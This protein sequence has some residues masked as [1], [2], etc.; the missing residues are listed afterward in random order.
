MIVCSWVMSDWGATHSTVPAATAGLDQ[1]MPDASFFG[2]ALAAAVAAGS[3]SQTRVD[4]MATRMLVPMYALGMIDNPPT[5]SLSANAS[6]LAHDTLARVLAEQSTVLLKN[7]GNILPLSSKPGKSYLILGDETTVTGHGSGGVVTPYIITPFQGI[8]TYLNGPLPPRPLNCTFQDNCD[9]Y[10]PGNPCVSASDPQDCCAQCT[11]SESCN[12]FTFVPNATCGTGPDG[13]AAAAT[14]ACWLK[15]DNSGYTPHTGY[16]SGSC[17][18][19]PAPTGGSNVTVYAGQNATVAAAMAASYDYVIISVATTSSEGSDRPDLTLPSWQDAMVTAVAAVN[20]NTI[21][22]ARCPGACFMVWKDQVPAILFSLMPGQEAG[23]AIA[24]VIFGDVN[25]SGKLPVS[26]PASMNDTWLGNPVNPLQYP[27]TQRNNSWLEADYSENLLIGYRWYDQQNINPLW[28][29]GHGLSYS[30]WTYSGL[31]VTGTV[32]SSSNATVS[33]TITN[34]GPY[35]AAE[36]AQLYLGFPTAADEPPKLLKKFQKVKDVAVNAANTINFQITI[37]DVQVW[38]T[39]ADAW[40]VR[41]LL[42]PSKGGPMSF[43]MCFLMC[44]YTL[45]P[46]VSLWAPP[47]V[48]C[49]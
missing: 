49:D 21:V 29:F 1:Q 18:P 20:P 45:V 15:P 31:S 38:N 28:P 7:D 41:V 16:T 47:R 26:F 30:T 2:S 23:N 44:R 33:F 6:S 35:V 42:P 3:V 43:Y 24:N 32:S 39:I 9:Y 8:T 14:G 34:K 36:V 40:A 11:D 27:G 48:I 17:A 10:Q 25:P 22:L 37:A 13:G 46:T 5:G 4:D 12:A 19:Q